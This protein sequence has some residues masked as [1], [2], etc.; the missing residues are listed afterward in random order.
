MVESEPQIYARTMPLDLADSSLPPLVAHV[1]VLRDS[2]MVT[3]GSSATGVAIQRDMSCA[4]PVR[5][6]PALEL[7]LTKLCPDLP[8]NSA[9]QTWPNVR[10]NDNLWP[11][12]VCGNVSVKLCF[13][14]A[15]CET[16]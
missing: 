15:V 13:T 2:L 7:V 1:T 9:N 6:F 12:C 10:C 8:A 5:G 3:V 4:M 14:V 11:V 16:L